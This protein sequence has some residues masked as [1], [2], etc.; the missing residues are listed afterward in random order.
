MQVTYITHSCFLTETDKSL[1]L[2]DYYEGELP[3][4]DESKPL[5]C[6]TSH[7]HSDHFSPLL[8]ENTAQH[9]S[10]KY[11]LSDDIDADMVPAAL[12]SKVDFVSPCQTMLIG[13]I[14]VKTLKSTDLGIAFVIDED[15]T[16]I[17][18]AGDLN[19]WRWEEES[20]IYNYNIEQDYITELT[21][22]SGMCFK[23]AFI[24]LDPR[25]NSAT[26][27][28]GIKL[29]LKYA[30][31]ENIFPMHLWDKYEIIDELIE[32][33]DTESRAAVRKIEYKGEVFNI[34]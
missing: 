25:Q 5:Y 19:D 10:V 6:F 9:P 27:I 26:R 21:K 13:D 4:L 3:K 18:H 32:K 29:F 7:S 31:A 11:I 2:F 20:D 28:L 15:G 22:I 1:F 8:F 17:Y 14:T 16:N 33:L 23:A 12:S 24:P 34:D 30:N